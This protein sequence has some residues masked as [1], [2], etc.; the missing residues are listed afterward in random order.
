MGGEVVQQDPL[1]V[2]ELSSMRKML[3]LASATRPEVCT[4]RLDAIEGRL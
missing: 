1:F 3:K 4:A 2:I